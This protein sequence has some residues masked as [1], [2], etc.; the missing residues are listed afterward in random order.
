MCWGWRQP[1]TGA[2]GPDGYLPEIEAGIGSMKRYT[3]MDLPV[4][5][6]QSIAMTA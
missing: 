2:I 6:R 1:L 3:G 5:L 4:R